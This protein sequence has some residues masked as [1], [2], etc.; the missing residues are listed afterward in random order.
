MDFSRGFFLLLLLAVIARASVLPSD[1]HDDE[2]FP[3]ARSLGIP[4]ETVTYEGAQVWRVRGADDKAEY[5][6][7]LQDRGGDVKALF[8]FFCLLIV[9]FGARFGV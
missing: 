2:A 7:Y 1:W 8:L 3:E 4:E 5:L 9:F 6:N